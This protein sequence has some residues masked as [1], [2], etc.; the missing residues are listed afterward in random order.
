MEILWRGLLDNKKTSILQLITYTLV[1]EKK[2]N[3]SLLPLYESEVYGFILDTANQHVD[4]IHMENALQVCQCPLVI[5]WKAKK[6]KNDKIVFFFFN[7]G[8]GPR[9]SKSPVRNSRC[10]PSKGFKCVSDRVTA[11]YLQKNKIR[12][13]AKTRLEDENLLHCM[14]YTRACWKTAIAFLKESQ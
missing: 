9:R 11:S 8:Y 5:K 1:L 4:K 2:K 3:T 13:W 7:V 14:S 10:S 6:K 12:R